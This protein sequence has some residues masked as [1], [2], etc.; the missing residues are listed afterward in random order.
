[1][2]IISIIAAL[3]RNRAIGKQ[4]GMPWYLPADLARFKSLTMGHPI[5]MGRKTHA[6]IGKALPGRRNIVITRDAGYAAPGCEIA[7][8]LEDALR[9]AGEEEA[10]VIGGGEIYGQALPLARKLYLTRIDAAFDAD[11]FFPEFDESAWRIVSREAH[12][13]DEKNSH[14]FEFV[15]LER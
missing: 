11:T 1:M 7:G 3:D 9:L 14:P 12:A 2:A 6:S 13:P 5:L 10:F 4:G 15:V 8:S